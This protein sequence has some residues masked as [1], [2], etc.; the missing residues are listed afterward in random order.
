[1][2]VRTLSLQLPVYKVLILTCDEVDCVLYFDHAVLFYRMLDLM[3]IQV[4]YLVPFMTFICPDKKINNIHT[5]IMKWLSSYI[6]K[7]MVHSSDDSYFNRF[8]ARHKYETSVAKMTTNQYA[9]YTNENTV[10]TTTKIFTSL[11]YITI[12]IL[13]WVDNSVLVDKP[14]TIHT[15]ILLGQHHFARFFNNSEISFHF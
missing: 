8:D 11:K 1:M 13:A 2:M 6:M 9:L 4:I 15:V 7:W 12:N 5:Y 10:Y 3:R 14:P